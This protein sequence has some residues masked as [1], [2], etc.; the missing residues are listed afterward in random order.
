MSRRSLAY[1][2]LVPTYRAPDEPLHVDLAHHVS[3]EL[4][5]PAWDERDTGS[6][7]LLPSRHDDLVQPIESTARDIGEFVETWGLITTRRFWG[8]FGWFDVHIPDAAVATASGVVIT[9]ELAGAR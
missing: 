9:G 3:E 2:I 1:S 5:Y 6:G 8:D 7:E 4:D